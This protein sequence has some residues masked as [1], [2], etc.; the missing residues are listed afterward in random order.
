MKIKAKKLRVALATA[1][2]GILIFG[3]AASARAGT[4]LIDFE[5]LGNL[6]GATSYLAS[7]GITISGADVGTGLVVF[8]ETFTYG[9]GVV[10]APSGSKYVTQAATNPDGSG[11][12]GAAAPPPN[13]FTLNFSSALDSFGFSDSAILVPSINSPWT[14][15]AYAGLGGTGTVLDTVSY[16]PPS[17]HPTANFLLSGS[18]IFSVTFFQNP[19]ACAA[20]YAANLDNFV[21]TGAGVGAAVPEPAT[22]ALLGLGLLGTGLR[23]RQSWTI[24]AA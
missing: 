23:R 10:D 22:I 12:G 17:V 11:T 9:G 16:L 1:V 13:S 19:C 4:V 20:F 8:D 18:S 15:T 21:L 2:A 3:F 14:A 7:F 5:A 6:S 24:L